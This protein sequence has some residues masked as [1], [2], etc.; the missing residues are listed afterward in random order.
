M[1]SAAELVCKRWG[2]AAAFGLQH[3]YCAQLYCFVVRDF[4]NV[5]DTTPLTAKQ[6][7]NTQ[8]RKTPTTNLL[9]NS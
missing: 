3:T 7:E 2:A 6:T 8:N 9:Q 1:E 5:G 4:Q